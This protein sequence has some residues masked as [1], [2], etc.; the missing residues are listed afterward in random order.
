MSLTF[1]D[2][3]TVHQSPLAFLHFV[4]YLLIVC[5]LWAGLQHQGIIFQVHSFC[6]RASD[7]MP[8]MQGAKA[9]SPASLLFKECNTILHIQRKTGK[10]LPRKMY[11]LANWLR[12]RKAGNRRGIL[13]SAMIGVTIKRKCRCSLDLCCLQVRREATPTTAGHAK[14]VDISVSMAVCGGHLMIDWF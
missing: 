8:N 13:A 2:R 10:M 7:K 6:Q 11:S 5:P 3:P 1:R 4:Y 9:A 12:I 14:P